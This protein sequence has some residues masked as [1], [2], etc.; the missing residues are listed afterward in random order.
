MNIIEALRDR[1]FGKPV[2]LTITENCVRIFQGR[3]SSEYELPKTC[4]AYKFLNQSEEMAEWL[5][6]VLQED[7]IRI[8]R[9]RIVLDSGQVYLQT[10]RLP[11]MTAQEQKNWVRWEGCRYVPFD[12]GNYQAVLLRW[13]DA[14]FL[15][16]G[17]E[18]K[19]A[20]MEELSVQWQDNGE[21][22]LQDYLLAAVPLKVIEALQ[23]FAVFLKAKLE[24]VTVLG[25]KQMVLPVNLLPEASRKEIILKRGYQ[26]AAVSCL[27]ISLFLAVRGVIRWQRAKSEWKEVDRQLVPF[28]SFKAAYEES[29]K[30]EYR[31][32]QYRKTLQHISLAEPAWT[33]ALQAIERMIPEGCWLEELKQKQPN[34]RKIEIRGC[35]LELVL[36][37]EFLERLKQEEIFSVIRLVESGTKRF[38]AIDR[39]DNSKSVISFLLLA[40]LAPEQAEEGRP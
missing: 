35:A 23:Q 11:F 20:N 27:F 10:V 8:R 39:E 4:Q 15:K 24:A 18:E 36:I 31:I 5:K 33:S 17:Q 28:H 32:R 26:I 3:K 29:R 9:C 2:M 25:P 22:G 7:N 16:A 19:A 12:P 37:S 30:T 1:F 34:S 40:E 38:E 14:D 6:A 21:T 13:P